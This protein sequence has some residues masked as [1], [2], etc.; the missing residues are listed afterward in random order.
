M[1]L[2]LTS[3]T[4]LPEEESVAPVWVLLRVT[5]EDEEDVL[6]PPPPGLV[7]E[8]GGCSSSMEAAPEGRR[9]R[10]SRDALREALEVRHE[11]GGG[12]TSYTPSSSPGLRD[13]G[14]GGRIKARVRAGIIRKKSVNTTTLRRRKKKHMRKASEYQISPQKQ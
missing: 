12:G 2:L 4:L 14:K 7:R 3:T 6:P 13:G 10:E 1:H 8:G 5:V 11:R 9:W